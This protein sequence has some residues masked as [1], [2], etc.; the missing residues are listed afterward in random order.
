MEEAISNTVDEEQKS[1]IGQDFSY[2]F[3]EVHEYEMVHRHS[4]LLTVQNS[5]EHFLDELCKV[6]TYTMNSKIKHTDL[7]D[8][9]INR[10]LSFLTKVAGFDL[11][12]VQTERQ[13][14]KETQQI[15]NLIVHAGAKLPDDPNHKTVRL[16]T[17]SSYFNGAPSGYI[18]IEPTYIEFYI[19]TLIS[20]FNK[21]SIQVESFQGRVVLSNS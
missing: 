10:A 19:D 7:K 14:I 12:E 6:V 9:G 1:E 4:I 15:R 21:L 2:D 3:A 11:S 17:K 5:L 20:F 18:N 8:H 13:T 16:V